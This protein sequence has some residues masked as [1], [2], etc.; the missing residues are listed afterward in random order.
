MSAPIETKPSLKQRLEAL[1]V[2][3]GKVAVITYFVI[4]AGVFLGFIIAISMGAHVESAAGTAGTVGAAY[5]ATKLTQP[6]RILATLVLTPIIGRIV[7]KFWPP[8]PPASA[9]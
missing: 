9:A 5:V 3:F 6:L 7:H 8:K 1:L 4:F 2:E